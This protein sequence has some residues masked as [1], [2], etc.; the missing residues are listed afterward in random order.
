VISGCPAAQINRWDFL[1]QVISFLGTAPQETIILQ[2][3]FT[4]VAPQCK[5]LQVH[6]ESQWVPSLIALGSNSITRMP[7]QVMPQRFRSLQQVFL[8]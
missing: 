3:A 7:T 1:L 8:V 5:M 4:Q 2:Q 6:L